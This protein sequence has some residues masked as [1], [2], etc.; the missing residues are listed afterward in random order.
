M[1]LRRIDV[2][3]LPQFALRRTL[4]QPAIATDL[5]GFRRP[6]EVSENLGAPGFKITDQ[7]MAALDAIF[8]RNDV[9]IEPPGW[10]EDEPAA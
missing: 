3:S 7:D 2:V 8:T 4:S 1:K 9:V 6:E 10:L 5:A